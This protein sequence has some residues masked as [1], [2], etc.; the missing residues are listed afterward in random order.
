MNLSV[1]AC[2]CIEPAKTLVT[3]C[4]F[5]AY[6]VASCCTF[7]SDSDT[8]PL[9]GNSGPVQTAKASS[10]KHL[11]LR[12]VNTRWLGWDFIYYFG[13]QKM[14]D[15]GEAPQRAFGLI[16]FGREGKVG[17]LRGKGGDES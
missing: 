8:E 13:K 6:T 15:T 10:T 16:Y 17:A 12:E 14:R 7:I 11:T 3:M 1:L 4:L 2:Y 9:D 5:W